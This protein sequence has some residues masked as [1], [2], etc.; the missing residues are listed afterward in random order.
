MTQLKAILIAAALAV[1]VALGAGVVWVCTRDTIHQQEQA[2]ADLTAQVA[3][4]KVAN[5]AL[6]SQSS[7]R[8]TRNAATSARTK[9]RSNALDQALAA[10][11][12]WA[13]E[14]VPVDV[15]AALGVFPS[16][17]QTKPASGP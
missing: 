12:T 1:C 6:L 13:A 11:P 9:E 16:A 10:N 8:A 4:Q 5:A 2:I 3:A 17:D 7:T 14:R 15:S